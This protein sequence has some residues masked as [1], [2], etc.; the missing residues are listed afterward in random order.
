MFNTL[1]CDIGDFNIA[2]LTNKPGI[3]CRI[4][5]TI[6]LFFSDFYLSQR[7]HR[8]YSRD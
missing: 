2:E 5:T 1:R 6:K 7:K 3:S 4:R 8:D